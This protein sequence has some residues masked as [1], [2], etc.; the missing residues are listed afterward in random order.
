ML[1]ALAYTSNLRYRI[2]LPRYEPEINNDRDVLE[3]M[4]DVHVLVADQYKDLF[5]DFTAENHAE[6]GSKVTY[7]NIYSFTA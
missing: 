7:Q 4:R 3:N 5:F 2:T 1:M 6:I